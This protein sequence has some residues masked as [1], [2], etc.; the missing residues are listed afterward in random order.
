M[1]S[2]SEMKRIKVLTETNWN[3]LVDDLALAQGFDEHKTAR[4]RLFGAIQAVERERDEAEGSLKL[5]RDC[6]ERARKRWQKAHPDA[7]YWPDGAK[8]IQWLLDKL[9]DA[10]SCNEQLSGVNMD[11]TQKLAETDGTTLEHENGLVV[12]QKCREALPPQ[13]LAYQYDYCP[14]CG[15]KIIHKEVA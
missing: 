12:C 7:N 10:L 8:N 9:A 4:S 15:R 14:A 2:K 1:T 6:M 11:L 13:M 3:K 5:E